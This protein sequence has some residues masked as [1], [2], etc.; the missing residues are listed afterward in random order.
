MGAAGAVNVPVW[1][2]MAWNAAQMAWTVRSTH[3]EH[4]DAAQ[5]AEA[6]CHRDGLRVRVVPATRTVLAVKP[7]AAD[8]A[9]RRWRLEQA[10]KMSD[11][12]DATKPYKSPG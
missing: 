6:L 8:G 5:H 10:A 11:R 12:A 7:A 9:T 3:A 1:R 2:V 4:D